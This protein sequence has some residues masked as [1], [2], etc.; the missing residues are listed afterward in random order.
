MIKDGGGRNCLVPRGFL[1]HF[2]LPRVRARF[3][4]PGTRVAILNI[5]HKGER[6]VDLLLPIILLAVLIGLSVAIGYIC[7]EFVVRM[8]GRGLG[9]NFAPQP[10]VR[11][12]GKEMM[13]WP[14][15]RR[16]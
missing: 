13:H 6:M 9:V 12:T 10:A 15:V 14:Q 4:P 16:M 7:L 5:R 3:E 8:I 2:A 11:R 1:Y